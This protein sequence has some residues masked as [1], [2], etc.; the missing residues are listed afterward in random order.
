MGFVRDSPDAS[1]PME[2]YDMIL[3]PNRNEREEEEK[4][5]KDVKA[6]KKVCVFSVL[7]R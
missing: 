5:P 4:L 6:V 7:G 2:A 1:C 3:D